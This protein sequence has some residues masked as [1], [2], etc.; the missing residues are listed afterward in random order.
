MG[1]SGDLLQPHLQF[2]RVRR[3]LQCVRSLR[4]VHQGYGWATRDSQKR[5]RAFRAPDGRWGLSREGRNGEPSVGVGDSGRIL[6][7][8]RVS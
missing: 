4:T 7:M 3:H 1:L 8:G 2:L 5:G 6:N